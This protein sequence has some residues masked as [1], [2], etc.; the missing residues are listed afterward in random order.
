MKFLCL[1]CAENVME[2]MPADDAAQHYDEYAAFTADLRRSG[3]LVDC[4]RLLPTDAA[5]T[6][7]VRNGNVATTDGPYAETKEHFGGYY[8]IDAPSMDAAIGI[9]ARIPGASRGCV[10]VRPVADDEQTRRALS[11]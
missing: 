4:N 5:V 10:E 8:L 9:A 3:Q 1:I 2:D 7:R 6:V 11:A